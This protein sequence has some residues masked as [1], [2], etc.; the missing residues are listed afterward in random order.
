[1]VQTRDEEEEWMRSKWI[2]PSEEARSR[3]RSRSPTPAQK[4]S[5]GVEPVFDAWKVEEP[6]KA[7]DPDF[8]I[9]IVLYQKTAHEFSEWSKE[10]G[11]TKDYVDHWKK[12]GSDR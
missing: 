3:S 5:E 4:N 8:T 9:S 7:N 6:L 1:M 10:R 2:E 12:W 11:P